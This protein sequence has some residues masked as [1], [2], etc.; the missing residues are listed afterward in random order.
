MPEA[1]A[2]PAALRA[3][4]SAYERAGEGARLAPV[5]QLRT[6][7]SARPGGAWPSRAAAA[8]VHGGLL[9]L[10]L[11]LK[12]GSP[13]GEPQNAPNFAV[14]FS[15]D[16]PD[17]S[18]PSPASQAQVNLGGTDAP[19]PPERT[20]P[21]N[22][23]PIPLPQLHY[24]AALQKRPRNP[25]AALV[26]NP[27]APAHSHPHEAAI[28]NSRYSALSGGPEVNGR[29]LTDAI[30]HPPGSEVSGDYDAELRAF[31][32]AHK[33]EMRPGLANSPPGQSGLQVT[34]SR[35]GTVIGVH[36]IAPSSSARLNEAWVGFFRGHHFPPL[37]ADITGRTY[38]V[39]YE[40]DYSVTDGPPPE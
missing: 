7:L 33:D 24:G 21:D 16:A 30:S 32:E 4:R 13:P 19:P 37:S 6:A 8:L 11:L 23:V 26:P 35:D 10:L 28:P 3:R 12:P 9:A 40:L 25:F 38:T 31:V 18:L 5:V 34:L 22:S 17:P 20:D 39:N 1:A 27:F 15:A 14:E 36:L 29:R 2:L